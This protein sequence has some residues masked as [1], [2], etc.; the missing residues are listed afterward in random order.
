PIYGIT[1]RGGFYVG[2]GIQTQFLQHL[3]KPHCEYS[4]N[5]RT[6]RCHYVK[7]WPTAASSFQRFGGLQSP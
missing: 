2:P 3:M 1:G 7:D 5:F 4:T 6:A